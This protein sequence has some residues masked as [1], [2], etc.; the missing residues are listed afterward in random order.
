MNENEAKNLAALIG[1]AVIF[2]GGKIYD[3]EIRVLHPTD[4]NLDAYIRLGSYDWTIRDPKGRFLQ[5]SK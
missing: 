1:G 5:A 3:V 4:K 2:L